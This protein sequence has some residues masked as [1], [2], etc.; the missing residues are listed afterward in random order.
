MR[1]SYS[2]STIRQPRQFGQVRVLASAV[3]R[4]DSAHCQVNDAK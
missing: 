1:Y 3:L 4:L 2:L